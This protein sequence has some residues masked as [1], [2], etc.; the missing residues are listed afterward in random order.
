MF[1]DGIERNQWHEMVYVILTDLL[2]GDEITEVP[3]S[4]NVILLTAKV[5]IK[6]LLLSCSKKLLI[7]E[8]KLL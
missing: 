4:Y 1:S 7:I 5:F 6:F 3:L 2:P 8:K